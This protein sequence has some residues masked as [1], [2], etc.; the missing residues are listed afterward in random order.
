MASAN[1]AQRVP[2]WKR[3]GLAL[4]QSGNSSATGAPASEPAYGNSALV[5]HPGGSTGHKRKGEA[6]PS[7]HG[8]GSSPLKKAR[9]DEKSTSSIIQNDATPSSTNKPKK[10]VKFGDTPSKNDATDKQQTPSK[11]NK[12]DT[13]KKSK[14]PAKKNKTPPTTDVKPALE[15]LRQWNTSRESW[16]FNKNH[17]STL[18]K[19]IF[20]PNVIPTSDIDTLVEY[21]SDLKG[22]VRTRLRETAMEVQMQDVADGSAGFGEDV[23]DV[24]DKQETYDAI[25]ADIFRRKREQSGKRKYYNEAQFVSDNQDGE[26]I[27]RR[28]VKR[29]RAEMIID[30]LSDDGEAT[31]S[32]STTTSSSK[33]ITNSDTNA[34]VTTSSEKEQQEAPKKL[35]E[36]TS[37]R[38]R[39]KL[40]TMQEDS[41]SSDSSSSEEESDDNSSDSSSDDSDSD[42]E[43]AR[44]GDNGETSSSS[45]SSSSSSESE[46]A[47]TDSDDSDEEL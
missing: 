22:F 38:R 15:Y 4:K 45:S 18:I 24:D 39:K 36:T 25:L 9:R 29:M 16:K 28:L 17:Q 20:E 33:T 19:H 10:S 23:M 43:D 37:R 2:A 30:E 34:T 12:P 44:P 26:V 32:T 46:G 31:D 6:P 40:R 7:S 42:D 8:D 27:M 5:G 14:G 1:S 21:L 47:D 13:P 3:L 11:K 35:A 41:S